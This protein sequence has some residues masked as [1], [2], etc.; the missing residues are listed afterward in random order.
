MS[1]CNK[2]EKKYSKGFR[3]W[4]ERYPD[5]PDWK[6]D[7]PQFVPRQNDW[8]SPADRFAEAALNG[9]LAHSRG[10][11]PHGYKPRD[12]DEDWKT[13]IS[14]EAWEISDKMMEERKKREE[15]D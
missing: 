8:M 13:S 6:D 14:R 9:M 10:D 4:C 15:G 7:C 2:C 1:N 3:L 5:E 11:P 12:P